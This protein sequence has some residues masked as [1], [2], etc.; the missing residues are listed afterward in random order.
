MVTGTIRVQGCGTQIAG[1]PCPPQPLAVGIQAMRADS[2]LA[3]SGRSN[4]D[5][6]YSF[7]LA[8]GV[9][10]LVVAQSM[11]AQ[12][13]SPSVTISSGGTVVADINCTGLQA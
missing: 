7:T 10:T 5:G 4:G 6:S 12:C 9:Y 13:P 11:A 8:P 3:A 1:Q 2:S